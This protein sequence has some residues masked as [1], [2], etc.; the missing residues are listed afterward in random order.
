MNERVFTSEGCS[1][2]VAWKDT[3]AWVAMTQSDNP[4]ALPGLAAEVRLFMSDLGVKRA[5]TSISASDE[6]AYQL[7]SAF[8]FVPWEVVMVLPLADY[9]GP[10]RLAKPDSDRPNPT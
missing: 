3:E 4:L 9:D 7:A 2:S 1:I 10:G 8:G 6:R 5:T